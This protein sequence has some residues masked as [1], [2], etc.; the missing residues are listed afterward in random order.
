MPMPSYSEHLEHAIAT[1]LELLL[2]ASAAAGVVFAACGAAVAGVR[3][4]S[5]R[6]QPSV[7]GVDGFVAALV[8]GDFEGA[9][10]E[11]GRLLCAND[12]A[13]NKGFMRIVSARLQRLGGRGKRVSVKQIRAAYVQLRDDG[14]LR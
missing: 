14:Q 5:R 3:C 9:D 1:F 8:S 13:A 12:S 10:I 7:H 4:W 11:A 2:W 6:L